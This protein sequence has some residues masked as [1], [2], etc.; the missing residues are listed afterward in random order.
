MRYS[1]EGARVVRG[2]YRVRSDAGSSPSRR[3]WPEQAVDGS[4]AKGPGPDRHTGS[5]AQ[6]LCPGRCFRCVW[7][8]TGCAIA[9]RPRHG[10]AGGDQGR[11]L[12]VGWRE[13]EGNGVMGLQK[14]P[15]GERHAW[16]AV[17]EKRSRGWADWWVGPTRWTN[18]GAQPSRKRAGHGAHDAP[19]W[20][21]RGGGV[22]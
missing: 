2:P 4:P 13:G 1:R 10:R 15:V 18:A 19:G 14:E 5:G 12:G 3:R 7:Q 17:L 11:R 6:G 22:R 20:L 21:G 8:Q 16:E 9:P